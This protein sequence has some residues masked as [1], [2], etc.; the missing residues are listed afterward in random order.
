MTGNLF[1]WKY[2]TKGITTNFGQFGKRDT[3]YI[4]SLSNPMIALFS[5]TKIVTRHLINS[6]SH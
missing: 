1:K 3:H 2:A 4:D 6:Q 5:N